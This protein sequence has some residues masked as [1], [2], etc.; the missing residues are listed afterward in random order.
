MELTD[1]SLVVLLSVLA[2]AVF[3]LVVAGVPR[4]GRRPVQLTLRAAQVL[5]LNVLV[6]ALC[7]AALNDQYFFYSSWADLFGSRSPALDVHH[8]GSAHEVVAAAVRGPGLRGLTTPSTLPPLAQPGSR[9]QTYTVVAGRS[10]AEG[11]VYVY[12][13]VGYDPRA[14]R[15]YPVIVGLHGFPSGPKSFLRLSFLS[16]ID[17]L[18]AAHRMAPSIVV[19]PRIDTPA[20]LDTEC[21]NGAPGQPQTDT[22]LSR[23]IPAWTIHHFRVERT[24]TAWATIGYSYGAWCAAS[25][26]M[27]HPDVFGAS[28]VLL[29]YFRPDFSRSYDPLSG[30]GLRDY[31]LVAMARTSPPPLA[32]WVLTSRDDQL[33]YPSTSRFLSVAHAPLDVAGTVLAHGGHRNGVFTPYVPAALTWLAQTLPGFHA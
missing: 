24:R 8:G 16:D 11:Q 7:G 5:L 15:T 20:G 31:D 23:D 14:R 17:A 33:S 22:W 2:L 1:T 32:M 18:T 28:I 12:L 9:L 13:P 3:A 19:V 4:E 6:V 30:R 27:R 29:G 26:S 21:V 10:H 25:V